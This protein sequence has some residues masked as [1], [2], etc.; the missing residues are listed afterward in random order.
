MQSIKYNYEIPKFLFNILQLYELYSDKDNLANNIKYF[1]LNKN[2]KNMIEILEK[3]LCCNHNYN[4]SSDIYNSNIFNYDNNNVIVCFSGGKDSVA[5]AKYYKDKGYNVY[6]YHVKGINYSYPDEYERA[7]DIANYLNLPIFIDKISL[8]GKNTYLEHPMKNQ[9]IVSMALNYGITNN[10][11]VKIAYGDF[12]SDKINEG[13][14]DRNWSDTQEMWESYILYIKSY[15][16]NFEL[17]I[18]FNNY[19]NTL[20]IVGKDIVLLNKIQGCITPQRFREK[21][22]KI[23]NEKYNNSN[24]LEHRCGS[25]WKCCVEYIRYADTGVL[26]YNK[27]FYKHCVD[28][29]KKKFKEEKPFLPKPK[30]N[31]DIYN[32]WLFGI[33]Y[34]KS[35]M[36]NLDNKDKV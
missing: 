24:V 7:I 22:H 28:I 25:C 13:L 11:G 15:I 16:E 27:E 19:L 33:D 26:P 10:I 32:A 18:P 14:F 23:N 34:E 31:K 29:L 5:T 2:L 35:Y 12:L 21:L 9:I 36:K 20:D 3:G 6:L 17:L 1:S 8:C 4:Y 30:T